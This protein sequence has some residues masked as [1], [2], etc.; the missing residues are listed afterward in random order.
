MSG[1]QS[2]LQGIPEYE[3]TEGVLP[4]RF[5]AWLVDSA[6]IAIL[7][8]LTKAILIIFG[9]LTLGLGLPLLWLLPLLPIAYTVILVASPASA[10]PGQSL[11]D[12]RVR[13]D[14]DLSRPTLQQALIY[15]LGF[16]VTMALGA[17]WLAVALFTPRHRALHDLVSGVVVVR[18]RALTRG[19]PGWNMATGTP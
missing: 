11:L 10:T 17:I 15:G 4:R 14:D 3:L 19:G 9:V 7:F 12:L 5:F 18:N 6:L 13:R 16:W 2:S 1:F 8:V